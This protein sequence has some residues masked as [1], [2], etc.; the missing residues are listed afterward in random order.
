MRLLDTIASWLEMM[1][2]L[3]SLP[4]CLQRRP[5]L[6]GR[7]FWCF[8]APTYSVC[9][10]CLQSIAIAPINIGRCA[11]CL[12]GSDTKEGSSSRNG[13]SQT[14]YIWYIDNAC[15]IDLP[16]GLPFRMFVIIKCNQLANCSVPTSIIDNP[17]KRNGPWHTAL[18][19]LR[20]SP[21]QLM[22]APM[23]GLWICLHSTIVNVVIGRQ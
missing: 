18:L 20:L 15:T 5:S 12:V 19:V 3:F 22:N 1:A 9:S 4:F 2:Y 8:L 11:L 23:N 14:K 21:R 13:F 17:P 6:F 10:T 7:S 16:V